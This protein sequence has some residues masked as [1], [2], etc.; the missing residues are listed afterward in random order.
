MTDGD[1]PTEPVAVP[2][3][4]RQGRL[5]QAAQ[6]LET[7]GV[8]VDP[9][10]DGV[11]Y[12]ALRLTALI[13]A[14]A[15]LGWWNPWMLVVIL[16]I[17]LM[18]TLHE[19]GHFIMAKRAGM[20]VTEFFLFFGPKVWS[21]KRGETEYGIKCIPAGAYV[22]I[23]GMTNLE[24][25]DPADEARTYRQK[26]FGQRVG[27]AVAGSAMHFLLALVL[28]FAAVTMVGQPA[29]SIDP[30]VQERQWQI[31]SVTEGTGAAAVGLRKGDRIVSIAGQATPASSD[32]RKVARPYKGKTVPIVYERDG[33][34]H[35]VQVSLRP[36]YTW[37]V[38]RVPA[39]SPVAEAG[40]EPG[41]QIVRI[42]DK[43]VERVANLDAVL[44]PLEGR[45]VPITY[46][47]RTSRD[48][49]PERVTTPVTVRSLILEGY[50]AYIGVGTQ[51][52]A[53]ERISPIDG[54]VQAP[55]DFINVTVLSVQSLGKFFTPGGIS[56]FAS[57]LGSAREDRAEA[58]PTSTA[59]SAHLVDT[60]SV[61]PSENRLLSLYGLV[62]IGSDVGEVNPAALINL[63]ALINIFIGVFNLVPLLPF[64]GGHVMIAVY[65][66]IQELRLRRRRYFTDVA[67]L[68]PIT[69]V[70]VA[71][72]G[73][74]FVST[75]YLDIANPLAT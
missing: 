65:E 19:L 67:R 71:A 49:D 75:L 62:R 12:P 59:T 52:P 66:R 37:V 43:P 18:I 29:G 47:R 27:V 8:G 53:A 69:Y 28:I 70:V 68:L 32:L 40:L 26:T 10:G 73:L 50:E 34:R 2:R 48:A 72:L 38:S 45:Q 63:F 74:L 9:D 20:K 1:N 16:A 5:T 30:R 31:G 4:D 24:E 17:V 15:A 3:S 42:D 13:A 44:Q 54:V 21:V 23:I 46:E 7:R 64:D 33:T 61:G 58:N 36:Y 6:R 35:T 51:L 60:A 11:R 14:L 55:K 22:K 57:Q 25:V 56:D 41:D 39:G